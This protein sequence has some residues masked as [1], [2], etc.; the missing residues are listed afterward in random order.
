MSELSPPPADQSLNL[1]NSVLETVQIGGMAGRDLKLNQIQRVGHINVFG[2]ISVDQAPVSTAQ[3]ISR[4]EYRW[5]T[6]LLSKVR[7]FWIDGVL[8]KA[9]H[10]KVLMDLGL[11][12]RK[13]FAYSPLSEMEEFPEEEGEA[14]SEGVTAID[15][16]EDLG[17]G[18]TMLILGEPG[19]GKTVT[20]LKLAE[21][22]I[23][24]TENDLSQP[25]PVVINLSSWAKKREA[26]ADW[27]VQ[28]L[29]DIY[30]VSKS[31]GKSWIDQEQL[32]LLLDGL[33]EV[34]LQHRNACVQALNQFIQ[35]HGLTEIVVCSRIRD[36]EQLTD[37]LKLRSAIYVKPLTQKQINQFLSQAGE[38]LATLKKVLQD[39]A[40]LRAF[41]SSP[42]I[43]SIM[44]LSYQGH[45]AEMLTQVGTIEEQRQH[46]LDTYID[47]MFKRRS[48]TQ[49]YSEEKTLR[50]LTWLGQRMKNNSQTMFLI[51]RLQPDWLPHWWQKVIYRL[52]SA[53]I[54]GVIS[55]ITFG[56][57]FGMLFWVIAGLVWGISLGIVCGIIIGFLSGAALVFLRKIE[58]VETLK[59]SWQEFRKGIR[60]G[61][62]TYVIWGFFALL[63]IQFGSVNYELSLSNLIS[64]LI[65][66]VVVFGTICGFRGPAIRQSYRPNQGIWKSAKNAVIVGL[67]SGLIYGSL[68]LL[69]EALGYSH[70]LGVSIE[71]MESLF[72][73]MNAVIGFEI[74]GSNFSGNLKNW[75]VNGLGEVLIVGL[76]GVIFGGGLACFR[77]FILRLMLWYSGYTP[78]NYARFLDDAADHLFLQKVGG[79]YIFVH[80]MLLEYF[81]AMDMASAKGH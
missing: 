63:G 23:A 39:N 6:V 74:E 67:I 58:T 20:L 27:L 50:W 55:G 8:A 71:Q 69:I 66:F 42:L 51:E 57:I 46:L 78:W 38:L 11:E 36:Y 2:S 48:S 21:S 22:L 47:R 5:R 24:R 81:A 29:R 80:R 75:L 28:E 1:S 70:H 44:S 73:E 41:A 16:F 34:E 45:S 17:V 25:L 30:G 53:L 56:T 31:L 4:Q 37:H 3:P 60:N 77:H 14:I 76:I 68:F 26:I 40:E 52:A 72:D 32:I 7:Q 12:E 64:F 59:W 10:T 13:Q 33:D 43:L 35:D 79:G 54:F 9:L 62:I 19:S 65:I 15:I 61:L 18:R 49:H